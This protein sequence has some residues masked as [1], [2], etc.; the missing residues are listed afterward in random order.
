M[1]SS[2]SW[3][4]GTRLELEAEVLRSSI[5]CEMHEKLSQLRDGQ[6]QEKAEFR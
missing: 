1:N 6:I 2:Y 3:V 4:T 5:I